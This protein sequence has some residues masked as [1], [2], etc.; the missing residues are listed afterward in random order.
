CCMRRIDMASS[1]DRPRIMSATARTLRGDSR[2]RLNTA[3]AIAF[4]SLLLRRGCRRAASRRLALAR[5]AVE[6]PGRRELAQLVR[7]H[8]LGGYLR[9]ELASVVD[10]ER[11]PQHLGENGRAAR[12]RLDD[13]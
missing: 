12:P 5:V 7:D 10:R 9:N 4:S 2:K 11:H 3:R 8:V 13:L 6:R 1:T